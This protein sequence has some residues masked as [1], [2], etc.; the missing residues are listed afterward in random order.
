MTGSFGLQGEQ[1]LYDGTES[2]AGEA[3]VIAAGTTTVETPDAAFAGRRER[4]VLG[5]EAEVGRVVGGRGAGDGC[6]GGD[7]I[8]GIDVFL[9]F[10]GLVQ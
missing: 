10:F 8:A 2:V 5:S 3:A 7:R 6:R 9:R 4:L 1:L